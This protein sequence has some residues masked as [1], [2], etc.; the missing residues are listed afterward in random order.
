MCVSIWVRHMAIEFARIR[1][2]PIRL[3]FTLIVS[4]FLITWTLATHLM[5][6]HFPGLS[7]FDYVVMGSFGA[8][9]L[10]ASVLIHELAH[11]LLALRYGL[12]VRGITLFIFG[13]VSDLDE[14]RDFRKEFKIAVAG[15]A[16]S[17]AMAGILASLWWFIFGGHSD[18]YNALS[19]FVIAEGILF[20]GSITNAILGAFNL[21]P[22]FPM[23]GGRILR[24]GL[25]MWKKDFDKSTRIAAKVG[26]AISYF[27]MGAGFVTLFTGSFVGGIWLILIGWFLHGGAQSYLSEFEL[28]SV[29]STTRLREI[30]N[31]KVISLRS[32]VSVGDA[33]K[34]YFSTHVKSEL[35]V[36]DEQGHLVGMAVLKHA[37]SLPEPK[38]EE[39]TVAEI[40]V[41]VEKLVVLPPNAM[42]DKAFHEMVNSGSGKIFVCDDQRLLI[43]I[44]SKT[45]IINVGREKRENAAAF[46]KAKAT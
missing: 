30:M 43:G 10:F 8:I 42:A 31:A 41:P 11:S 4:F 14:T 5:P 16:T 29:L 17:L 7:T 20:Y 26:I 39:T 6:D 21:V 15:P 27:F 36:V 22:A 12:R 9:T 45:D 37:M 18:A 19:P 40:M 23:D 35:P 33:V 24:A 34:N 25:I 3:H 1:N 44:V 38:R 46:K 32:G 13:G 28:L 2:I